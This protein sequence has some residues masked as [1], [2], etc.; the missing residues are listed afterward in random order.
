MRRA[1][2]AA[3]A[4][5]LDG[6]FPGRPIVPGAILLAHAADALAQRGMTIAAVRRMK[7][8]APLL[9][10]RDFALAVAPK[11]ADAV[12]RW[13]EGEAVLAEAQVSLRHGDG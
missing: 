8:R 9:P 11:G 4:P 1:G 12:L 10:E 3:D 5:C 6:H 13:T 7:F 2:I